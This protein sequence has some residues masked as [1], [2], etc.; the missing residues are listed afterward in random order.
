MKRKVTCSWA[1][2]ATTDTSYAP[3]PPRE[4]ET[5]RRDE[6]EPSYQSSTAVPGRISLAKAPPLLPESRQLLQL[7]EIFFARHHEAEFC[8]FFHKPS[9]DVPTLYD[10][11]PCL[12]YSVLS[13]GAL[14]VSKDE[15]ELE[16]GFST[17][18]ALSEHYARLAKSDAFSL[19]DEPSSEL[20]MS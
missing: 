18:R 8:S 10:R 19:C 4:Q 15:V 16:F 7:F 14:Y 9:L 5:P 13:L 6:N 2:I 1:Q 3:T 17:P 20:I 12:V 11:S